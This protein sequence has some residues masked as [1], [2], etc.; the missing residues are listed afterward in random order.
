MIGDSRGG[1]G[2][3]PTN[4]VSTGFS[5]QGCGHLLGPVIS[6]RK[7]VQP[8]FLW[9]QQGGAKPRQLSHERDRGSITG[10]AE[11]GFGRWALHRG[12]SNT[13]RLSQ[14]TRLRGCSTCAA[15][16]PLQRSSIAPELGESKQ[17]RDV[18]TT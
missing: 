11:L 5:K 6:A 7:V 14:T 15:F 4:L 16:Q 10:S 9:I 2:K 18:P 1:G 12:Q 8:G 3:L 13:Q 17:A